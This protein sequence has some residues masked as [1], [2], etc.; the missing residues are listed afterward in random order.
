MHLGDYQETLIVFAGRHLD[1]LAV[2]TIRVC[3]AA[4]HVVARAMVGNT[5]NIFNSRARRGWATATIEARW[6]KASEDQ[7]AGP[8]SV[9]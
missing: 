4:L 2:L 9:A 8:G 6:D 5:Q 1:V 3:P 7:T